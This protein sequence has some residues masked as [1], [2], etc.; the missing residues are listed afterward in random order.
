FGVSYAW[1]DPSKE[2]VDRA[3]KEAE[4]RGY[5]VL[6]DITD[7]HLGDSF[8]RFVE[9]LAEDDRTLFVILSDKYLKSE[10]CMREL[11]E[12]WNSCGKKPEK[13]ADRLRVYC[14][15]DARILRLSDQLRYT[16][17]WK[18]EVNKI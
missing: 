14:L 15:D 8:A 12:V 3:C 7:F 4:A 6:R 11:L 16:A 18:S 17:Y 9:R 2:I 13:F 5:T 10:N 1:N